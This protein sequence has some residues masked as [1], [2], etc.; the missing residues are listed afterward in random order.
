MGSYDYPGR[1]YVWFWAVFI[2]GILMTLLQDKTRS[3]V[4]VCKCES[5]PKAT[6]LFE[7]TYLYF[8]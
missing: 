4:I 3:H 7:F 1:N 8:Y 5:R 6:F 2:A